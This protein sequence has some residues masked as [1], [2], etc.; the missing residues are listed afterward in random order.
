M[1]AAVFSLVLEE[2][3]VDTRGGYVFVKALFT[4]SG[5]GCER[6]CV[7]L[8]YYEVSANF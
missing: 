4:I 3:A 2:E 1:L 7:R 6:M 5:R 8:L